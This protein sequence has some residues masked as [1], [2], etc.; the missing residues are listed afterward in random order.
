MKKNQPRP[1]AKHSENFNFYLEE[2]FHWNDICF[3]KNEYCYLLIFLKIIIF[4]LSASLEN[5][6]AFIVWV[7]IF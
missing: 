5:F 4:I 6:E 3:K 7:K 2:S 1:L